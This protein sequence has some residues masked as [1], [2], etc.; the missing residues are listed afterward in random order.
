MAKKAT[1]KKEPKW[2]AVFLT[3]LASSCNVKAACLAAKVHRSIP[4]KRRDNDDDFAKAWRWALADGLDTLEAEAQRR[5]VEGVDEPIYYKGVRVD[6]VK[7]YSDVLLMFLM[8]SHNPA[9]FRDSSNVEHSGPEGG[10]I[11]F[12]FVDADAHKGN[13]RS[14]GHGNGKD[15]NGSTSK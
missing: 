14:K 11:T 3:R 1:R 8:K 4:Y 6:T 5:A 9:R 2:M 7:K 10:P 13:G 15:D 12:N